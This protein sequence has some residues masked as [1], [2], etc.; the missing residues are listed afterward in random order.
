MAGNLEW[1]DPGVPRSRRFSIYLPS[2]QKNGLELANFQTVSETTLE[3][4]CNL[5]GGATS[6]S[7]NGAFQGAEGPP[8]KE[9]IR[10]V[11]CFC[12]SESW[13][14]HSCFLRVLVGV[15]AKVLNQ[16]TIGCALDGQIVFVSPVSW[17]PHQE[18]Q[19]GAPGLKLLVEGLI[20]KA[21][22]G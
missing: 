1:F 11:E 18:V 21:E 10:M 20:G 19:P 6:Y 7:A 14:E 12:K 22:G 2:K 4:L 8:Q 9:E 16:E 5:F 3:L 13:E 15:L 17:S